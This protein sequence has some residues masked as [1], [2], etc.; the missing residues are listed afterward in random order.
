MRWICIKAIDWL[1]NEAASRNVIIYDEEPATREIDED[2]AVDD[3]AQVD[4]EAVYSE[5]KSLCPAMESFVERIRNIRPSQFKE[6][7]QLKH[8]VR[9][10]NAHARE[11]MIEMHLRLA[12][13]IGFQRAKA[14]DADIE[15]TVGDACIGLINAVD[16]YDPNTSGPFS[17]YAS[18][19]ILQNVTREQPTQNPLMYFPVHRREDYYTIFPIL[20]AA[21][22]LEGEALEDNPKAIEMICQKLDCKPDQLTDIWNAIIPFR[23][24]N[25]ILSD[26]EEDE[27]RIH[28]A[29]GDD[30]L[31]L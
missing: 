31:R 20:K 13:R 18:L 11:R 28:L 14:Y 16:R 9:E 15:D 5:I 12:L 19:W 10:G 23:S 25:Q 26:P 27:Y 6:T 30:P 1:S 4:Y 2:E 21:G 8:L 17:S 29:F 24:L 3:Y 22:F 7:S